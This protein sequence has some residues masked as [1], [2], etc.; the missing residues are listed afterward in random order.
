MTRKL[1]F[2][3]RYWTRAVADGVADARDIPLDVVVAAVCDGEPT[4]PTDAGPEWAPHIYAS[5]IADGTI[6]NV[7]RLSNQETLVAVTQIAVSS[8]TV[9]AEDIASVATYHLDA[10]N[11]TAVLKTVWAQRAMTWPKAVA[12]ALRSGARPPEDADPLTL[13]GALVGNRYADDPDRWAPELVNSLARRLCE[14]PDPANEAEAER[15]AVAIDICAEHLDLETLRRFEQAGLHLRDVELIRAAVAPQTDLDQATWV[16]RYARAFLDFGEMSADQ[17][18]AV[19]HSQSIIDRVLRDLARFGRGVEKGGAVVPCPDLASRL[20]KLSRMHVVAGVLAALGGVEGAARGKLPI[21]FTGP[22]LCAA[23]LAA[24]DKETGSHLVKR[25]RWFSINGLTDIVKTWGAEALSETTVGMLV[26]DHLVARAD[27]VALLVDLLAHA[28]PES[29]SKR[30]IDAAVQKVGT[31][32]SE[33]AEA[34]G[35]LP[36]QKVQ[37]LLK[38]VEG[39]AAEALVEKAAAHLIDPASDV[40]MLLDRWEG[41]LSDLAA[42]SGKNRGKRHAAG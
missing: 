9:K 28:Q 7:R 29:R 10:E 14:T 13:V 30:R 6:A 35:A 5:S 27:T 12:A 24:L 20:A 34:V 23:V 32:I 22:R 19:M 41:T 15:V 11:A 18:K 1:T 42:L 17:R 33:W 38:V 21:Y 37:N 16:E 25:G 31:D 39:S 3:E 8:D 40:A 2:V 4:F 26:R 36:L